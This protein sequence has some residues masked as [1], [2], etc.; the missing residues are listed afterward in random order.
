MSDEP[1]PAEPW[2]LTPV[3]LLG[4]VIGF[5]GP[6]ASAFAAVRYAGADLGVHPA[7]LLCG[8]VCLAMLAA[9]TAMI[10]VAAADAAARLHADRE[11][12]W[13]DC[14]SAFVG[15][16]LG[17]AASLAGLLAALALLGTLLR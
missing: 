12:W 8:T 6:T 1:P 14:I 5:F 13:A 9:P 17:G 2:W 16:W 15:A 11:W 4:W 3:G 10:S 7:S